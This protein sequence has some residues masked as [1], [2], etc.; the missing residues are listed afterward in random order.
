MDE[1]SLL[2]G[3][4]RSLSDEL[5][6]TK[7]ILNGTKQIEPV[8]HERLSVRFAQLVAAQQQAIQ[9]LEDQIQ[10]RQGPLEPS[11]KQFQKISRASTT[12]LSE[13]LAFL[14]GLLIRHSEL[15]QRTCLVA[16]GLCDYLA[17]TSQTYQGFLTIPATE[18]S[19]TGLTNIIRIHFPDF[20]VWGL[21][22]VAHEFGHYVVSERRDKIF[23]DLFVEI[24]QAESQ[25]LGTLKNNESI[26]QE[27]FADLFAVY[28]TGPAYACT[29]ILLE[30]DP[31]QAHASRSGHPS[32]AE[33]SHFI[34]Q[35]LRMMQQGDRIKPYSW[36]IN[37]LHVAWLASMGAAGC[38]ESLTQEQK[39][40]LD[41]RLEKMY[42]VIDDPGR[43]LAG[44]HYEIRSWNRA[45]SLSNAL[46]RLSRDVTSLDDRVINDILRNPLG[47]HEDRVFLPDV[48]NAA[49]ICRLQNE[50]LSPDDISQGALRM[51]HKLI[52]D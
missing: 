1:R 50:S 32:D 45:T 2:L 3:Q 49:W 22:V 30:F 29:C 35:A 17:T 47:G 44:A 11:W 46:L 13:I 52:N 26:L 33:R 12:L 42:E 39:Q 34:L 15:D 7:R 4:L 25:G 23:P 37:R 16:D 28:T 6:S 21:P 20:S 36:I 19:F 51:C 48:L 41:G 8:L 18:D 14:G 43:Q 38:L 31:R 24:L 10:R 40:R 9:R 27:Q 5:A